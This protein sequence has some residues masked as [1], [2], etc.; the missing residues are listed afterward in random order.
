[1]DVTWVDQL[2]VQEHMACWKIPQWNSIIFSA[3][4]L[5]FGDF[6]AASQPCLIAG[7]YQT[8]QARIVVK[9]IKS[10]ISLLT[11]IDP[12][13]SESSEIENKLDV[14]MD[15]PSMWIFYKF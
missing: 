5:P 3:S 15:G 14:N 7:G 4:K 1:M 8:L 12:T 9:N 11:C 10:S 13:D 2:F 6:P